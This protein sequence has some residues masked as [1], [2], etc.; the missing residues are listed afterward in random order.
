MKISDDGKGFDMEGKPGNGRR[1]MAARAEEMGAGLTLV[2]SPGNG[3]K[4]TLEVVFT[5]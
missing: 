3:T 4:M 5:V 2:S 1:S